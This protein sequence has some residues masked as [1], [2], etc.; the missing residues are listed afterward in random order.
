MKKIA[1]YVKDKLF[2]LILSMEDLQELTIFAHNEEKFVLI[3]IWYK[4]KF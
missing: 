1:N 3:K 2:E 4:S